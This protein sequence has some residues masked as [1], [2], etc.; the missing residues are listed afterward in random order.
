MFTTIFKK[1]TPINYS[2]IVLSTLVFYFLYQFH[3][4]LAIP[5][6]MG[7]SEKVGV[8]VL[9]FASLFLANFI[10]KKNALTKDSSYTIYFYLVFMLFFPKIWGDLRLLLANFFVLLALR[11][12]VS[13]QTLKAPKEKIFDACLWIFIASLFQ[14]WALLFVILVYISIVFHV[15]RDFRN[16]L[17]PFVAFFIVG[18]IFAAYSLG[19]A[20]GSLS[21]YLQ[22]ETI[23]YSLDY[24]QNPMENIAFSMFV[25]AVLFF[26]FPSAITLTN[27]P[28]NLQASYKKILLATVFGGILFAISTPKSNELLI[29]M[30]FPVAV[31]ATNMIEY[32]QSKLQQELILFVALCCGIFGFFSQL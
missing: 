30:I 22:Q 7:I 18:M 10:V 20:P 17:I 25:V 13:L 16:W 9:I 32:M 28:L 6:W 15:S 8:L 27:K 4:G 24:F 21:N 31:M 2:L 5:G 3:V 19:I 26:L 23:N 12:L 29:F 14:F 1:S 11:R